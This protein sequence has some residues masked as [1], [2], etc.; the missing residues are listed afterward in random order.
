[1]LVPCQM[2]F[3]LMA[4]LVYLLHHNKRAACEDIGIRLG[5][6]TRWMS[7]YRDLV[8][9]A[10]RSAINALYAVAEVPGSVLE[11]QFPVV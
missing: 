3:S 2:L 4:G 7:G 11:N 9:L 10:S 6:D 1:M 5:E 8:G